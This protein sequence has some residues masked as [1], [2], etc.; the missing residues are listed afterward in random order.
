MKKT[1]EI[2]FPDDFD[3]P[4]KFEEMRYDYRIPRCKGC[5]LYQSGSNWDVWCALT[6][7][8]D[9]TPIDE[10]KPCPLYDK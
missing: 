8:G 5:P 7:D 3:F 1:I 9:W 4:P 2:E 10:R 6:G